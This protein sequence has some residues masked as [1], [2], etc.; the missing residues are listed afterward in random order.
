MLRI[1]SATPV[2]AG[3]ATGDG[4]QAPF[5][6]PPQSSSSLASGST[7]SSPPTTASVSTLVT[8]RSAPTAAFVVPLSAVG[9]ILL[10]AIGLSLRHRRSLAEER[11]RDTEKLAMSRKSSMSSFKSAGEVEYALNV[12]SRN[13]ILANGHA[14]IPLFMPTEYRREER[15]STRQ[16]FRAPAVDRSYSRSESVHGSQVSS[17]RSLP[18]TQY[19]PPICI[20]PS[21]IEADVPATHFVISDYMQPSPIPPSSLLAAP[22]RLYTRSEAVNHCQQYTYAD[23]PLPRSPGREIDIYDAVAANIQMA[24]KR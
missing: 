7:P 14:P 10:V 18:R 3:Q 1:W 24:G 6:L 13:D 12:L 15:Q 16:P 5:G 4:P 21:P 11:A 8:R 20:S 19:L 2:V 17:V 23:K 9:A 22:Q